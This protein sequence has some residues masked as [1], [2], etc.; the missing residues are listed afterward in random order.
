MYYKIVSDGLIVDASESLRF[1]RWQEKNSIFLSCDENDA[2]GIVSSDGEHVYLLEGSE[3]I[4]EL[5]YAA[6]TE[7]TEE[8]YQAIRDELDA[9]GEVVNPDDQ[10]NTP[11]T[12]AKTRL[13]ALEEQMAALIEENAMLTECLLEMSEVVYGE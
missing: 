2:D 13:A 6:I 4:G 8:E 12:P 9:G 1:V 7:I 11:D 3:A 5:P 10:G